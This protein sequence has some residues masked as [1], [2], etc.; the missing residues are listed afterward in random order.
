MNAKR[1]PLDIEKDYF[2]LL[3]KIFI[4]SKSFKRKC[5]SIE[6]YIQKN[7][8]RLES[9]LVKNKLIGSFE[10]LICHHLQEYFLSK[11]A[12]IEPFQDPNTSDYCWELDDCILNIDAKTVDLS[13]NAKPWLVPV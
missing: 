4:N 5:K 2:D 6:M 12:V 13:G 11:A 10:R 8:K 9:N 1:N 3:V 7:Y